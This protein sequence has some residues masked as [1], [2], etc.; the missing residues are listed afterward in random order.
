VLVDSVYG[1]PI[2][3]F[4]AHPERF[5]TTS[6]RDFSFV[7]ENADEM[8]AYVLVPLA[9]TLASLDRVNL[10]YPDLYADGENWATLERDWGVWRLYR[11]VLAAP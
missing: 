10:R 2:V 1:A 3:L 4:S 11:V 8:V 7:L 6:D 9:T 5:V